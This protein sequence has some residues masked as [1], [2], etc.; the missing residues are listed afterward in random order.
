MSLLLKAVYCGVDAVAQLKQYPNCFGRGPVRGL[1]RFMRETTQQI[2]TRE[3][4]RALTARSP[5]VRSARNGN[6]FGRAATSVVPRSNKIIAV[7][8]LVFIGLRVELPLGMT[9]DYLFAAALFPLWFPILRWYRGA[10]TLMLVGLVAIGSGFWLSAFASPT[11]VIGLGELAG[12]SIGLFGILCSI[13]FVL[14]ARS[15]LPDSWVA[16]WLGLG[17]LAGVSTGNERFSDNP[18]RFGFSFAVTVVVLA[19]AHILNRRFDRRWFDLV[20]VLALTA[21]SMLT[22]ARSSFAILFLAAILV[23]WQMRPT[24][25]LRSMRIRSGTGVVVA[26][27]VLAVITYNLGQ[28]AIVAGLFGE[29]TRMRTVDQLNTAGSLILGGRPELAATVSLM[30]HQPY[31]FGA[32]TVLNPADVLVAKTGMASI[33][34]AP[35]NGYVENY[36]FGGHI[37]LHS[38]LGDLWARFGIAG[39]VL[40]AVILFLVLRGVGVAVATNRASGILLFL[41]VTT[42]WVFFFGPLYS[43]A[44]LLI[45]AVALVLIPKDSLVPKPKPDKR[46]TRRLH[47]FVT[48]HDSVARV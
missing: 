38:V 16:L 18:W 29:A 28:A 40:A 17:L 6:D 3:S 36:M 34:Y 23:A 33:N 47:T 46:R 24:K 4:T 44:R 8:A 48:S 21:I 31:G 41:V 30:A 13:G 45:L 35:D 20:A 37:E 39:L 27:G 9:V 32:G 5:F 22:D 19:V 1:A 42:V 11:H 10:S 15:V 2:R 7:V 43:A 26:I 25:R 12:N 14:W